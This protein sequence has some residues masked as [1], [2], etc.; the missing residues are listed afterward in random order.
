[1]GELLTLEEVGRRLKI[2]AETVRR[3]WIMTG[4][5]KAEKVGRQWR[6]DED[7]I[8]EAK[9]R[10][11]L[12]EKARAEAALELKRKPDPFSDLNTFIAPGG[13][14]MQASVRDQ[15]RRETRGREFISPINPDESRPDEEDPLED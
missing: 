3:F 8:Q 7:D 13:L 6:V 2:K 9:E 11:A 4:D 10:R 5:L 1:M 12:K 14:C 15:L